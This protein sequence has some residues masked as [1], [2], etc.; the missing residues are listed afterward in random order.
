MVMTKGEMA[1]TSEFNAIYVEAWHK[2]YYEKDN[3]IDRAAIS[4]RSTFS[5]SV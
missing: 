5:T 3:T 1:R 2:A 4:S